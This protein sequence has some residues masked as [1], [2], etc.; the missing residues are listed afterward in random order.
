[1]P[2]TPSKYKNLKKH[3]A[4]TAKDFRL[5]DYPFYLMAQAWSTYSESMSSVLKSIDMDPP[6]WR[7]LM[8]LGE[9][10]PSS[11]SAIAQKAVMKLSTIT[12]I[13]QRMT[14]EGLVRCAPRPEDNRVTEVFI[15]ETGRAALAK[16]KDVSAKIYTRALEGLSDQDVGR[17]N[18]MLRQ[19]QQNLVRSPYE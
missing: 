18:E 19:I 13:V 10:S 16:V 15:T 14:D 7:V 12:R 11:I 5:D 4:P 6:R 2:S 8:I 3:A 9:A 1:M 17:L